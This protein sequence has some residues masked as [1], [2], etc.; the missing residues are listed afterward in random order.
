MNYELRGILWERKSEEEGATY[1]EIQISSIDPITRK[2]RLL[3]GV[4]SD[5]FAKLQV[6]MARSE[7]TDST[8]KNKRKEK[9]DLP[10]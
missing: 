9:G 1:R 6:Q 4:D 3:L 7:P 2:L 5:D 8:K 10:F